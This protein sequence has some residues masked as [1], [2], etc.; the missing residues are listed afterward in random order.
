M[1]MVPIILRKVFIKRFL[2][3]GAIDEN[4]AV[5]PSSIRVRQGFIFSRLVSKGKIVDA[6][7]GKYFVDITRI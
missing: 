5:Q 7:N 6:G 4:H 2:K 3:A 1:V